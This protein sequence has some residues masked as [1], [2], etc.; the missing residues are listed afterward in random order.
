MQYIQDAT[1]LCLRIEFQT[2]HSPRATLCS[3]PNRRRWN[4]CFLHSPASIM[5][6]SLGVINQPSALWP[7]K[8]SCQGNKRRSEATFPYCCPVYCSFFLTTI[9][10]LPFR[11][12]PQQPV[13]TQYPSSRTRISILILKKWSSHGCDYYCLI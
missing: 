12:K 7:L 13:Y 2:T 4:F 8:G 10:Q 11:T 5:G 3:Y 6:P 1:E 9:S